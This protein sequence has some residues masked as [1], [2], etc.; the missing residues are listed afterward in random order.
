M[1]DSDLIPGWAKP[2]IK[3]KISIYRFSAW[4]LALKET[5]SKLH[6]WVGLSSTQKPKDYF[7]VS[8]GNLANKV[9]LQSQFFK[10]Q[11]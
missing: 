1:V 8:L 7:A 4:R 10:F 3:K 2:K 9:Q 6:R 5:E 11:H